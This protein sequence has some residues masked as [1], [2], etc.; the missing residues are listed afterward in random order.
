MRTLDGIERALTNEMCVIADAT[1][2]VA[3]AG[4]MGGGD[5]EIR[6]SSR[7]I[8]LES[9]W[10][11]PISIRRTSK[12]LGLRTEASVRFERGAD[13]EMA[14]TASRRCAEL[15]Q[16]LG[17]GEILMGV[18]DVYPG[19]AEAP[20]IELTR[21]EFL[22]VIGA[23]VPDAEIEAILVRAWLRA[24]A[25]G[26]VARQRGLARSRMEVQGGRPGAATWRARWTSSKKSREFTALTNF[27]RACPRQSFPPRA[28][29]PP[30]PTTA[31]AKF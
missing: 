25:F 23:D 19:R 27:P 9:A 4:V 21:K 18:V 20:V 15:I 8:L 3:I 13:M 17:G 22:R 1:R 29:N 2:A 28:L 11:D 16:Q 30:K 14:E 31:C 6:S 12:A 5:S 10:F 7:N 26:C 24:G